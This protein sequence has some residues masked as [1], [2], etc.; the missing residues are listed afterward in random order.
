MIEFQELKNYH[1]KVIAQMQLLQDEIKQEFGLNKKKE[2]PL[3]M[4]IK[5]FI[6]QKLKEQGVLA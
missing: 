4:S 3:S 6:M 1:E 5:R 2:N